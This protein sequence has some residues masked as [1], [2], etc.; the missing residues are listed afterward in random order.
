MGRNAH[1]TL[2]ISLAAAAMLLLVAK[3][4]FTAQTYTVR[5]GDTLYEIAQKF[6]TTVA[7]LQK[8]NRLKSPNIIRTGQTLI[9]PSKPA[10]PLPDP[11]TYGRSKEDDLAV[12]SG[13]KVITGLSKGSRFVVLARDGD[14]F[15]VKLA[16]GKTGWIR[17]DAV[18]LEE[19]KPL[20]AGD[21]SSVKQ[22]I[23]RAAYTYRGAKYRYGGMSSRGFDCSGFVKFLYAKKSIKLPHDSRAM[24]RY[25]KPVAK[26]DLQPGDILFFANTYRRGISHVGLYVG[27]GKFIHAS[28]PRR[29]VREDYLNADYYRRHYVG[30]R[31]IN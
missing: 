29:G 13:D 6:D 28:T 12:V 25:G 17:A 22:D 31:R 4:G 16:D 9:V 14:K 21:P 3:S 19:R 5:R 11:V 8:T 30:A 1:R 7:T 18:T 27:N 26:P 15:K 24:F 23:V 10:K 2:R 20:P